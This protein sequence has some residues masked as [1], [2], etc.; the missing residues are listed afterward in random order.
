M[1]KAIIQPILAKGEK[2]L[3]IIRKNYLLHTKGEAL[4]LLMKYESCESES[5]KKFINSTGHIPDFDRQ[6]DSIGSE[7][8]EFKKLYPEVE[9][10]VVV[11]LALG[12]QK[13][14]KRL[15]L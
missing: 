8:E 6:F 14:M 13:A 9:E 5:M 11:D 10:T 12:L 2:N 7:F 1:S 3:E 15:G 4:V